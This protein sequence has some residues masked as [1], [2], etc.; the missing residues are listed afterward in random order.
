MSYNDRPRRTS[1]AG[2]ASSKMDAWL[3][4]NPDLV[5][6]AFSVDISEDG[7]A[8]LLKAMQRD[9]KSFDV[10]KHLNRCHTSG[11]FVVEFDRPRLTGGAK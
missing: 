3:A 7:Y 2:T 8:A 4:K 9:L 10:K 1:R 6:A 11:Q 5:Q